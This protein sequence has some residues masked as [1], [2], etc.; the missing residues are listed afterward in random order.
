MNTRKKK[1]RNKNRREKS[2]LPENWYNYGG[3]ER[4]Y[5]RRGEGNAW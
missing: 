3:Q 1:T 2:I 4:K 5:K